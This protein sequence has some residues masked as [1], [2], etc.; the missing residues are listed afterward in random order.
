LKKK[1]FFITGSRA[2]YGQFSYFLSKLSKQKDITLHIVVTGMHLYKKFGLTYK[3]ILKEQ[4][5]IFKKINLENDNDKILSQPLSISIGLNKFS[6]LFTKEKPAIVCIPCDRYEM[7]APSLACHF[8]NIPIVHFYG[9]ETS[10]G[11]I[12]NIHRDMISIMSKYHLISH[13]LHQKKLVNLG[14]SKNKIFNI[15]ILAEDKIK[16][17]KIL[18][19]NVLEKFLNFKIDNHTILLS[20]HPVANNL[21]TTIK[22]IDNILRALLRLN[23]FKIIFTKPNNDYGHSQI[24]KRISKFVKDNPKKSILV[25]SLGQQKYYS[26]IK[27]V[28]F[29]SGNSSSLLYEVPLF[30]KIS[31]NIGI[32]QLGR[33]RNHSVINSKA[34]IKDIEN[35]M[36]IIDKKIT[37]FKNFKNIFFKKNPTD[38]A[39][40]VIR[41]ACK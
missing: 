25:D 8:L 20:Y 37:N 14:I 2:E 13:N 33:T 10:L 29:V 17:T 9:G 26:L 38:L 34:N 1:V 28:R 16:R 35:K 11:S 15:G 4:H 12:D 22:E 5:K 41:L 32:R 24:I 39:L 23:R 36:I 21:N 7:L 6:K 19:K 31:L 3:E 40:K 18:K 27:Y 30:K